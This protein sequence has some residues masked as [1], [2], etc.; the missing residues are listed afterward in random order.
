LF[1]VLCHL[2]HWRYPLNPGASAIVKFNINP[3]MLQLV[4]EQGQSLNLPGK[5]KISTCGSLPTKRCEAPGT[6]K[7]PETETTLK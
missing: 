7:P 1:D 5:Y 3:I 6:A 4:N 2:N